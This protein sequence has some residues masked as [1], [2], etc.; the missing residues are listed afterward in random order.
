MKIIKPKAKLLYITPNA[1]FFIEKAGRVCYKSEN[2]IK[3]GT[4]REFVKNLRRPDGELAAAGMAAPQCGIGH[5]FCV[6]NNEGE[7]IVGIDPLITSVSEECEQ[8]YEG[9][10][11]WPGR[12]IEANRYKEVEIEYYCLDDKIVKRRKFTG[13]TS[14]IWQH[15]IDHLDGVEEK[16]VP[17]DFKTVRN[18]NKVGRN[19]PCPCGSG[20]KYKK[21]CGG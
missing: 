8:S 19:E 17:K 13:F 14:K 20:K 1:Q 12:I 2:K 18:T 9:C 5:R 10:L 6:V 4:S 15:E 7:W 16:L 21:C 11:S 3:N